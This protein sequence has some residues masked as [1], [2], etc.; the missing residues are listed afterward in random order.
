MYVGSKVEYQYRRDGTFDAPIWAVFGSATAEAFASTLR[1]GYRYSAGVSYTKPLT[2]K[3]NLF[4]A[5]AHNRRNGSSAVF[6][7]KDN[8]AKLNI[9]YSI[10]ENSTVYLNTEY[11]AGDIVSSGTHT[12]K[13]IDM[14]K[15]F[16]P[17]DVYSRFDYYAYRFDGKTALMTLGWNFPFGPKDSID[18][19]FQRVRSAASKSASVAGWTSPHYF[20]S[21]FSIVYLYSF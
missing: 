17:D 14:A 21:Q 15:V 19:S 18:F 11:R 6:D 5:L 9:D 16:T 4:G 12:L 1:D 10:T 2:D 13:N 20:D 7:T 8:S 3:I